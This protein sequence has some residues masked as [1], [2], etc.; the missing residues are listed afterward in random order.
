MTD[1]VGKSVIIISK[2]AR[3]ERVS[4]CKFRSGL[5]CEGVQLYF[6]DMTCLGHHDMHSK[7]L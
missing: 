7:C 5:D 3:T 2:L 1:F 6:T 4:P